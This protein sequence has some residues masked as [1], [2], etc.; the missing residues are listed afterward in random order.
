MSQGEEAV[1]KA[2]SNPVRRMMLDLV[3]NDPKTTSEL[4]DEFPKLSRYAVMQ[5]IGVLNK[6]RVLLLR[7][8]GRQRFN[9]LNPVPIEQIYQRW[10]HP[11]ASRMAKEMLALEDH[12]TSKI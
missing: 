10:M 12:L 6:A 9:Y 11:Y 4:I 3:R 7:R 8:E 1:W 2:L 5:H